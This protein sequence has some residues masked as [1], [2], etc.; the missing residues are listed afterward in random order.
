MGRKLNYKVKT[1]VQR[2]PIPLE[3]LFQEIST[4]YGNS[5]DKNRF[6]AEFHWFVEAER[7]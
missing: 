4:A 5:D 2:L 3:K 7:D 1:K 6:I